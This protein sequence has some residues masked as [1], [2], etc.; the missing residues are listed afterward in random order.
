MTAATQTR[1]WTVEEYHKMIEAS[2]LTEDD[3]VEL[4]EGC[5][6]HMHP[7][8]PFHA[9]TT[10]RS[11]RYLQNLLRDRAFIRIRLPITL[12]ASEPEPDI[13]VV[14]IDKLS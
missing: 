14:R 6:L 4:L 9:G 10:Q 2:I 3:K 7:Q 5:I 12:S 8:N 11:D 1:L 13:A